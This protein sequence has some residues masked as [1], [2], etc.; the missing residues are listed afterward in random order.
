VKTTDIEFELYSNYIDSDVIND[1]MN[2]VK[3]F[4]FQAQQVDNLLV[5][6]GYD[7]IFMNLDSID[8]PD[9]YI[10]KITHKRYLVD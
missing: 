10:E 3:A 8:Y 1:I 6:L 7:E 2:Y 9:V 5:K 4:G